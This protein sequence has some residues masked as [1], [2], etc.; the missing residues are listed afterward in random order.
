MWHFMWRV[1]NWVFR[2]GICHIRH[3]NIDNE[4][5]RIYF[6]CRNNSRSP[7]PPIAHP[8]LTSPHHLGAPHCTLYSPRWR[9][10]ER[11]VLLTVI[12]I[13]STFLSPVCRLCVR[14][15]VYD[16]TCPRVSSLGQ[17]HTIAP[18]CAYVCVC[19]YVSVCESNNLNK[20]F[21][22]CHLGYSVLF[23]VVSFSNKLKSLKKTSKR[24]RGGD[25]KVLG[26]RFVNS[27]INEKRKI[28][29]KRIIQYII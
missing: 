8:Q 28:K 27:F 1:L 23:V 15:Y 21:V 29:T 26:K 24:G 18:H 5:F 2:F 20:Y 14:T 16:Y 22:H 6:T 3:I 13:I 7:P 9:R 4:C 10:A 17:V 25:R 12:F 19:V 11:F